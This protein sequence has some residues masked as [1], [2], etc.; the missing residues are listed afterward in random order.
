[1]SGWRPR[2]ASWRPRSGVV[3]APAG[4][5]PVDMTTFAE[6][7]LQNYRERPNTT[8]KTI[9]RVGRILDTLMRDFR[10]RTTEGLQ[11]PR[12]LA[13]FE[14]ACE[15]SG[16]A[17]GSIRTFV[18][19]YYAI[20]GLAS[21]WGLLTQDP[22]F[23]KIADFRSS[24]WEGAHGKPRPVKP[25]SLAELKRLLGG[26]GNEDGAF[27]DL[28]IRALIATVSLC[29]FQVTAAIRLR[30]R[31][32]DL[33]AGRI[34]IPPRRDGSAGTVP[35]TDEAKRFVSEF[36]RH[37]EMSGCEWAFPGKDKVGPWQLEANYP[38]NPRGHLEAR[39][40]ERLLRRIT[41][42][43]LYRFRRAQDARLSLGL[44]ASPERR[45][46][47]VI[48]APDENVVVLDVDQGRLPRGQYDV[49][50][51]IIDAGPDGI[52]ASEIAATAKHDSAQKIVRRLIARSKELSDF[53][54]MPARGHHGSK[55]RYWVRIWWLD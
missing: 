1:M 29:R 43:M 3:T 23:Q 15:T 49:L 4:A 30:V 45:P 55:G 52:L 48:G 37:P 17:P 34:G 53:I 14:R 8:Q 22:R 11:D 9:Y 20:V 5:R 35:L 10:V 18:S 31:D 36:F 27:A 33:R 13:R 38:E 46:S 54:G 47:Y 41:F 26:V 12:L 2:S 42:P 7:V 16:L 24:E 51:A 6:L 44:D 19:T 50:K 25:V 39:C 40:K 32:F 28:R 21:G